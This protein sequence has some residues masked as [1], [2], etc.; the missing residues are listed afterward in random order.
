VAEVYDQVRERVPFL[1]RDRFG[2][3]GWIESLAADI[4]DGNVAV[5]DV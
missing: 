2:V 5:P 3:G 1:D 4:R